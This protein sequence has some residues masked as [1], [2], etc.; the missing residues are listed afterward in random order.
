ML[1]VSF[2]YQNETFQRVWAKEIKKIL[3]H[4]IVTQA[5]PNRYD[6]IWS[7]WSTQRKLKTRL[8]KRLNKYH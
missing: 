8:L 2:L 1:Y 5:H 4:F 7:Y 3:L 6:I